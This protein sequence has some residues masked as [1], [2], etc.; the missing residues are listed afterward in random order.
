MHDGFLWAQSPGEGLGSRFVVELPLFPVVGDSSDVQGAPAAQSLSRSNSRKFLLSSNWDEICSQVDLNE[1]M[2]VVE[3]NEREDS[4]KGREVVPAEGSGGLEF[5]SQALSSSRLSGL[6]DAIS[7]HSE[8]RIAAGP[9][10]AL[11]LTS[12]RLTSTRLF[13]KP[14]NLDKYSAASSDSGEG[15]EGS[16]SL[17]PLAATR[18]PE[19]VDTVTSAGPAPEL[20]GSFTAWDRDP[21]CSD[22]QSKSFKLQF[23]R[24]LALWDSGL[25]FLVVDDSAPSRRVLGRLLDMNKHTTSFASS[26]QEFLDMMRPSVAVPVASDSA[27]ADAE[28]GTGRSAFAAASQPKVD[29]V[30]MDHHMPGMSGPKTVQ[31]IRERGYKGLIVGLT[32]DT[33]EDDIS[34]FKAHGVDEVLSKPLQLEQL[35]LVVCVYL[36]GGGGMLCSA[37]RIACQLTAIYVTHFSIV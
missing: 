19:A 2:S 31:T 37:H 9:F 15:E 10:P 27:M 36:Q 14:A 5:L 16:A 30:L 11:S 23:A 21:S 20:R 34:Y 3:L 33:L 12:A 28:A 24:A 29:V 4:R 32:G 13:N 26:G 17:G 7:V 18:A 35:K 25:S 8:G 22:V 6:R 1:N